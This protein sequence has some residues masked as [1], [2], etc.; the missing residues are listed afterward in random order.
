MR[1]ISTGDL[2]ELRSELRRGTFAGGLTRAA[3]GA[4]HL[5]ELWEPLRGIANLGAGALG[6][7]V[8]AVIAERGSEDDDTVHLVWTGPEGKSGWAE[9]TPSALAAVFRAAT[10]EVLIAGYRFDHGED[11]LGELHIAMRERG[12]KAE[13]FLHLEPPPMGVDLPGYVKSQVG[14]FLIANW[15]TPPYPRIY[16]APH[17]LEARAHV[18]LHAKCVVADQRYAMVGSANFTQRGQE[19][20]IEVGARIESPRFSS[21]LVAHFH[22]A[23]SDGVFV[24]VVRS[25]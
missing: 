7:V 22:A 17:A 2:E 23:L 25:F 21:H 1:A 20:N 11:V 19:R 24:E 14:S 8:D 4:V 6:A 18:S 15:Q 13:V 5:G 10:R 12:V 9:P 16:I 3:L